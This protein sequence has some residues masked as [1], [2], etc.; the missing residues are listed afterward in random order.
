MKRIKPE[1]DDILKYS[2]LNLL[3]G[4]KGQC[5]EYDPE[6]KDK[7]L[8]ADRVIEDALKSGDPCAKLFLATCIAHAF[9]QYNH[10]SNLEGARNS[11]KSQRVFW[12]AW[13]C[14]GIQSL[15]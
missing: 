10:E 13:I 15:R 1:Y 2:G 9:F 6:K 12:R 4:S 8:I 7:I 5:G 3:L 11:T 14:I